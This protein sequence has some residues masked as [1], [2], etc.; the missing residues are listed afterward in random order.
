MLSL[1]MFLLSSTF[2]PYRK[3]I[4]QSVEFCHPPFCRSL[5]LDS[6]RA[7]DGLDITGP[8]GG[9]IHKDAGYVIPSTAFG[10]IIVVIAIDD[11][12]AVKQSVVVEA[13]RTT[14]AECLVSL[15]RQVLP[16][17]SNWQ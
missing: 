10:A 13:D 14:A 2:L 5:R 12:E 8:T 16:S 15:P 4:L 7:E 6:H 9:A 3:Y 11:R 1:S 17:A